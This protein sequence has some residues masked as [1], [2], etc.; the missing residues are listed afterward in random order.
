MSIGVVMDPRF[1]MKLLMFFFPAEG[2]ADRNIV[3]LTNVLNE[4]Y[5]ECYLED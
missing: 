1:K 5:Q 2:E 3:Y 4:L